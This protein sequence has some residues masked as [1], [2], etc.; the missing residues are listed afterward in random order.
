MCEREGERERRVR[1]AKGRNQTKTRVHPTSNRRE[2]QNTRTKE[3]NEQQQQQ[4]KTSATTRPRRT[5][6]FCPHN[7][8]STCVTQGISSRQFLHPHPTP[9]KEEEENPRA[10]PSE[11]RSNPT[12]SHSFHSPN[13]DLPVGMGVEV[14]RREGGGKEIDYKVATGGES[15]LRP[16]LAGLCVCVC[17]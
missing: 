4:H 3:R 8:T 1:K 13:T 11:R 15:C 9:K 2:K 17:V 16:L 5:P 12:L 6:D 7:N 10:V 14:W